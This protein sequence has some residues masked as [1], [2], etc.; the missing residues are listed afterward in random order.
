MTPSPRA[1]WPRSPKPGRG[2]ARL[3]RLSRRSRGRGEG[4][5]GSWS[6]SKSRFSGAGGPLVAS[7]RGQEQGG[8]TATAPQELA[9]SKIGS[10]GAAADQSAHPNVGEADR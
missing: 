3:R 1:P 2:E 10:E 8:E 4:R 6:Q 7:R 9:W 5:G